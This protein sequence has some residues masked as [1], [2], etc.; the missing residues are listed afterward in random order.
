MEN[1]WTLIEALDAVGLST[2]PFRD[3]FRQ[4]WDYSLTYGYDH[5]QGSF[6]NVGKLG[7]PAYRQSKLFWVQADALLSALYMHRL[8]GEQRYF[9]Y[10]SDILRWI[11]KRQTDWLEGEWFEE[12]D[13]AGIPKGVE[14]GE[15][16]AA[17]HHGRAVMQSIVMLEATLRVE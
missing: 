8:T 16:K 10:F 4:I 15:W 13:R 6:F 11:N 5:Q 17:Y 12:I 7:Q 2:G 9:I 14:A 3:F 1:V